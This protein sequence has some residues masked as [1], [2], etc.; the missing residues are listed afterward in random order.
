MQ[1]RGKASNNL[2]VVKNRVPGHSDCDL[3]VWGIFKAR[4]C[5][6]STCSCRKKEK[7]TDVQQSGVT[8]SFPKAGGYFSLLSVGLEMLSGGKNNVSPTGL[9]IL[10]ACPRILWLPF[11]QSLWSGSRGSISQSLQAEGAMAQPCSQLG[12][13]DPFLMTHRRCPPCVCLH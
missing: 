6:D 2:I 5:V 10:L 7:Q 3:W 11:A 12:G 1:K 8:E 4:N 9:K 13:A